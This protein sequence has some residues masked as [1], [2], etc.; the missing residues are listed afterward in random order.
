[1]QKSMLVL[2]NLEHLKNMAGK[3][4]I[5]IKSTVNS[6]NNNGY[7]KTRPCNG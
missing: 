7:L 3:A 1:M 2:T 6:T 4:K 5:F